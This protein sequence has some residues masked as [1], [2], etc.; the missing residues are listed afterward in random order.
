MKV[1]IYTRVSTVDKQD[2]DTQLIPLEEY[3]QRR[4]WDVYKIYVDKMSG[5]IPA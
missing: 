1:A 2:L 5:S 4:G 3:V